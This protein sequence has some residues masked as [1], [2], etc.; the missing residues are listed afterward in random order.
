MTGNTY[1][2][3]GYKG[4]QVRDNIHCRDVLRA[5]HRFYEAPRPGEAYNIGGGRANSCSILEA[6]D[7]VAEMGGG[8]L[9]TEYVDEPRRGDH[10]CYISDMRKLEGHY[11]GWRVEI[12]LR[13][14]VAEM[15]DSWRRR[16]SA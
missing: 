12:S 13:D 14:I 9:K 5:V 6:A 7:M 11:P 10:I 15:I 16:V 8:R 4:K 3:Y 1:R 2:I